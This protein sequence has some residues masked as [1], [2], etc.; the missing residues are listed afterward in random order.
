MLPFLCSLMCFCSHLCL[1]V[2]V[3]LQGEEVVQTI[4]DGTQTLFFILTS[5]II[6]ISGQGAQKNI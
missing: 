3:Y 2:F 4:S 1:L 5:G 6:P